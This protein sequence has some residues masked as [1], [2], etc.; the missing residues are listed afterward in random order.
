MLRFALAALAVATC[1][2]PAFSQ[3]TVKDPWVRAT[4]PEQKSSGAFMQLTSPTDVRLVAVRSKVAGIAE[5]HEMKMEGNV[6]KMAAV[7]GIAIPAGKT[8]ALTPG[9][10]HVMLMDLKQQLKDGDTVP[11][12]LVV[13]DKDKKMQTIEVDAPVRQLGATGA[14]GH[15]H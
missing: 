3:V 6:M 2:T 15:K 9:G 7:P 13:E 5:I 8:V 1:A 4:V 14:S 11:I 12:T 10:Y